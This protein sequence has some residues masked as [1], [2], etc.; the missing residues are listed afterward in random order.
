MIETLELNPLTGRE[1]FQRHMKT[2]HDEVFRT[3]FQSVTTSFIFNNM[4]LN[5]KSKRKNPINYNKWIESVTNRNTRINQESY[6]NRLG[7]RGGARGR[8]AREVVGEGRGG[9]STELLT[10]M[11]G[12]LHITCPQLLTDI[13]K[14]RGDPQHGFKSQRDLVIS[15]S[16]LWF[17]DIKT[18]SK[19][20]KEN[21]AANSIHK[22]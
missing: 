20:E 4:N 11:T 2:F 3:S 8:G 17:T 14:I 19:R 15:G 13:V 16:S 12:G 9:A 18:H 5:R 1:G 10:T 6:R 22:I 7:I 21:L